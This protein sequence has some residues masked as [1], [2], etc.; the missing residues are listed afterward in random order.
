[1]KNDQAKTLGE[2][3]DA[4]NI[5][6]SMLAMLNTDMQQVLNQY[7]YENL[8]SKCAIGMFPNTSPTNQTNSG[9]ISQDLSLNFLANERRRNL[10]APIPVYPGTQL[11]EAVSPKHEIVESVSSVKED[12]S[13]KTPSSCSSIPLKLVENSPTPEKPKPTKKNKNEK[14]KAIKMQ[15]AFDNEGEGLATRCDVVYKTILRDY[16][17]FFLDEYKAFN[18]KLR[19][20]HGIED[21]LLKFC[22]KMFPNFSVNKCKTISLDLGCLLFPK[23]MARDKHVVKEM[24][25]R[26]HFDFQSTQN[27]SVSS[28][29]QYEIA[30]IHGFL[31]KFSIDKI[32]QCFQNVSLSQLFDHYVR[33][34][35]E[36]RISSNL[37]MSKNVRVY[38]RAREILLDKASKRLV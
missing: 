35:G 29:I 16:R 36:D 22:I 7:I 11:H 10:I 28:H 26:N 37:T 8:L 31:Y 21:S 30:R 19:E 27:E 34:T 15:L 9:L 33:V 38:Q 24:E 18:Q 4:G 13:P 14:C 17:R 32:E 1:M 2:T 12:E 25:R 23:E 3:Q 6:L 5:T 20:R